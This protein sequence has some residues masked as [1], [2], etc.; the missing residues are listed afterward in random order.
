MIDDAD[1]LLLFS[2]GQPADGSV[3][4]FAAG[5]GVEPGESYEQ[6]ALREIREETGL[7]DVTL[8]GEV[9]RGRP[10]IAVRD[11]IEYE[12]Q[13]RYFLARVPVFDIDTSGFEDMERTAITGFRWWTVAEL[14]ETSDLL[15]PA[16][17][18]GLVERLL[19]DGP[20]DEP[21]V[22]AG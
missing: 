7:A 18:A 6:A 8:S 14:M 15:R 16:G 9:W 21:V 20:P 3:R 22:V 10:W 13:Q 1:R 4:W 2:A 19:A 11:G 12:V 17:L 5:G